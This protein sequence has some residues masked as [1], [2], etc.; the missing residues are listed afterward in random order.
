MVLKPGKGANR[1]AKVYV[2]RFMTVHS[3]FFAHA[4]YMNYATKTFLF[5]RSSVISKQLLRFVHGQDQ[6]TEQNIP[7]RTLSGFITIPLY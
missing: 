6:K 3:R 5:I 1:D 4:L 7:Q 2:V